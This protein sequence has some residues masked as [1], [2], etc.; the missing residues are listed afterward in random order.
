MNYT[1][2]CPVADLTSYAEQIDK[3]ICLRILIYS[4]WYR[5]HSK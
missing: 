2:A 4:N 3:N 1:H 5:R